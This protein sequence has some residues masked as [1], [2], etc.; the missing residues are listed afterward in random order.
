MVEPGGA[1]PGGARPGGSICAAPHTSPALLLTPA[2]LA[3]YSEGRLVALRV[4]GCIHPYSPRGLDAQPPHL[5]SPP[6][7]LLA[8]RRGASWARR[9]APGS[10]PRHPCPPPPRGRPTGR[11][12]FDPC[13]PCLARPALHAPFPPFGRSAITWESP[14]FCNACR[15]QAE[16]AFSFNCH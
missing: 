1:G 8:R 13:G 9:P 7:F 4:A 3:S 11:C 12:H 2:P 14:P 5:T 10:D 16:C 15:A 6:T